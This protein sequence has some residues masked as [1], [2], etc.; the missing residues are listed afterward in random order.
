MFLATI[1]AVM[2]VDKLGRKPVMIVGGT[3]MFL[4]H[5][6]I[7]GIYAQNENQWGTHQAAGWVCTLSTT[8]V[9]ATAAIGATTWAILI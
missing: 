7:A 6:I 8:L 2:Y 9:Y 1:P 5:F 4:C 3:G